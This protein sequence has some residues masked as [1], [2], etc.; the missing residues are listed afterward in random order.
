MRINNSLVAV[1]CTVCGELLGVGPLDRVDRFYA[2]DGYI[3][4]R[5]KPQQTFH[6]VKQRINFKIEGQMNN[7]LTWFEWGFFMGAGWWLSN[8]I[9]SWI[10]E[11]LKK[12][13]TKTGLQR[14]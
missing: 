3:M 2:P 4:S 8:R 9:L 10:V 11:A 13:R 5:P 14:L 1:R 12:L 6:D 7:W